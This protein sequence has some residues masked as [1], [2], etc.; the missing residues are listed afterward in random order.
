VVGHAG[1]AT[2]VEVGMQVD[3]KIIEELEAIAKGCVRIDEPM[4]RHTSLGLGGPVD[5]FVEPPDGAALKQCAALVAGEGIPLT[6]LGRG[7]NLL[8]RSGGLAG[9]VV[10]AGSAFTDLA[11]TEDGIRAGSGIALTRILGFCVECGLSGL[12]GLAGIPGSVGGAVV[13]NAGS[14]GVSMGELLTEVVVFEPGGSS[15]SM[16]AGELAFEYRRSHLPGDSIVEVVSIA[17]EAADPESVQVRQRET[18]E[19]KWKSQ[20]AGMRS[21][22]CVFRNPPGRSAGKIIDEIGLKGTRI[23]GAVV[24][25]LHA[26]FILNDRGATAEEVE[27]LIG[28]VRSRVREETGIQLELEVEIVGRRRH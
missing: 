14:F 19:K 1:G 3:R 16:P 2:T 18:L 21:A 26:G 27:E 12:E 20:P 10:T 17:L 7:T 28:L 5:I 23:G 11:R 8:V 4:A 24:S 22:G 9:A 25:D 13:T 6:V 15:V